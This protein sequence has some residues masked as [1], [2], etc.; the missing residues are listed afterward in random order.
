ML[1][2][3]VQMVVRMMPHP[4]RFEFLGKDLVFAYKPWYR[5][6]QQILVDYHRLSLQKL[7]AKLDAVDDDEYPVLTEIVHL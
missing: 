4:K 1:D 3:F 5:A 7:G 2:F 6:G